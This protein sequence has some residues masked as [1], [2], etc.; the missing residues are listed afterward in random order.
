MKRRLA[1]LFTLL[2]FAGVAW[3][4]TEAL[5]SPL[6]PSLAEI[7]AATG[8]AG[9]GAVD[10]VDVTAP[11]GFVVLGFIAVAAATG[12]GLMGIFAPESPKKT[13]RYERRGDGSASTDPVWAWD[14]LSEGDD[15]TQR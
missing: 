14:S 1:I 2:A 7:T 3:A 13:S 5:S 9:Q 11:T 6:T 4:W 12:S 15:P 10:G 8:I